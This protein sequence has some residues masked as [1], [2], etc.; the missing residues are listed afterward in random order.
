[1]EQKYFNKGVRCPVCAST[2]SMFR[3]VDGFSF[4]ECGGCGLVFIEPKVLDEIDDGRSLVN[5]TDTYWK[6]EL[7]AA[8]ERSR[9]VGIARIAEAIYFCRKPVSKIIDIGTGTGRILDEIASLLPQ[10]A[11]NFYGVEL[12]PPPQERT[13]SENYRIGTLKDLAPEKFDAGLCMEVI[14]HLT[15]KMVR[16]LLSELSLVANSGACFLFNT[17]L[18]PFVKKEDPGYLDPLNRGHIVSWTVEAIAQLGKPFGLKA[19]ALPGR[20]WAFL[21]EKLD[22]EPLAIEKRIYDPLPENLQFLGDGKPGA[23][24][25]SVLASESARNYFYAAQAEERTSWAL[26]L[27]KKLG[28]GER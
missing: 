1:M 13:T 28:I 20:N 14:E 19:T 10:N 16:N 22:N 23:S 11:R 4:F 8:H 21:V 26:S 2:S 15:P 24:L 6:S 18:V 3:T 12:Y 5:Y 9:S 7:S 27:Q 25:L 17:G